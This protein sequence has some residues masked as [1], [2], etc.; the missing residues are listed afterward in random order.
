MA[1]PSA[2]PFELEL[3][4]TGT[5]TVVIALDFNGLDLRPELSPR[6]PYR[7]ETHFDLSLVPIR[8]NLRG[9]FVATGTADPAGELYLVLQVGTESY[10]VRPPSSLPINRSPFAK[11]SPL[12]PSIGRLQRSG[13][14]PS[15]SGTNRAWMPSAGLN[16]KPFRPAP[17]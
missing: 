15:S 10:V 17:P 3:E 11:G 12:S 2:T 5:N 6:I 13:T 16:W 7:G 1:F 4:N 8:E 14:T 9:T